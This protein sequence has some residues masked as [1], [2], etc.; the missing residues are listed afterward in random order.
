MNNTCIDV[1]ILIVSVALVL[2]GCSQTTEGGFSNGRGFVPDAFSIDVSISPSITTVLRVEWTLTLDELQDPYV[3]YSED[4]VQLGA[5]D[6]QVD[7]DEF[8]GRI[9]GLQTQSVYEIRACVVNQGITYESS[10]ETVRTGNLPSGF[11]SIEVKIDAR[12]EDGTDDLTKNSG[13]YLVTTLLAEA[14]TPVI[15][16]SDGEVVWWYEPDAE[17]DKITRSWLSRDGNSVIMQA[18]S[19]GDPEGPD[20]FVSRFVRVDLDGTVEQ[21]FEVAG[22]HHDF[23][24]LPDGTLAFIGSEKRTIPGWPIPGVA[25][26]IIEVDPTSDGGKI[27]KVVWSA[28]DAWDFAVPDP[29]TENAADLTHANAIDYDPITNTYSLSLHSL[30][31]IIT[32]DR[33]TGEIIQEVGGKLSDYQMAYG[34]ELP[35]KSQHQFQFLDGGILLFDNGTTDTMASRALELSLDPDS[36]EAEIVWEH[37]SDPVLFSPFLGDVTR[38]DRGDT[39]IT[40]SNAGQ[41]DLIS[42]EGQVHWRLNVELANGFGYTTIEEKIGRGRR[43]GARGRSRRGRS[44]TEGLRP[45]ISP[46]R[47]SNLQTTE[48]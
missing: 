3:T 39:L 11:P 38:T 31:T 9:A 12:S 15:I 33:E 26:M 48:L 35:F 22:A 46:S 23:L 7:G 5:I 25:D 45:G 10:I 17:M 8:S 41:I 24:E 43:P 44:T 28:W 42:P 6:V 36:S 34:S 32:L 21:D 37:S 18:W 13:G 4:G 27:Q 1:R 19:T 2:A 16:D 29:S 40:W 30:G 20:A 14:A 47:E